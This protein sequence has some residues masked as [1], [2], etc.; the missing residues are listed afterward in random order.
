MFSAQMLGSP[1]ALQIKLNIKAD[2]A[3]SFKIYFWLNLFFKNQRYIA[4]KVIEFIS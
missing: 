4:Y 1:E 3:F 2:W